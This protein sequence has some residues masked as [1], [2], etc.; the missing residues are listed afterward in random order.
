MTYNEKLNVKSFI[1]I[2]LPKWAQ[3][4]KKM[5]VEATFLNGKVTTEVYVNQPKA[6]KDGTERVYK[7]SKALYGLK[8]NPRD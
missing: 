3:N 6:Y 2:L 8:E 5:D 7:L 1:I 4:R